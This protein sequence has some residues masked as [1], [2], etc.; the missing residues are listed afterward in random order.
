[1]RHSDLARLLVRIT[2]LVIIVSTIAQL[3]F[4][5]VRA[6]P[7][8]ARELSTALLMATLGMAALS[9]FVGLMVFW[10]AGRLV[11]HFVSPRD[12]ASPASTTI[13]L[14]PIEELA[15][16]ILGI[17]IATD[18]VGE[19]IYALGKGKLYSD[20]IGDMAIPVHLSP[21]KFAS[22][23]AGGARIIIGLVLVLKARGLAALRRRLI[24]L[25]SISPRGASS[26]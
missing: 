7:G 16:A 21:S 12:G 2:G 20:L 13:N 19:I 18:G 4:L 22:F 15:I 17:Y 11:D 23:L 10:G 14:Q 8:V 26:T 6:L 3:P 24:G 9:I 1:M 25:R 5:L